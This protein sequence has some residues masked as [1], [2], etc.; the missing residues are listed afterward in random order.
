MAD[1]SATTQT[2]RLCRMP[3][4]NG[5]PWCFTQNPENAAVRHDIAREAGRSSD[6][7]RRNV[8][9]AVEALGLGSRGSVQALLSALVAAEFRG[10]IAPARTRN[11]L[12]TVELLQR[13]HAASAV[14]AGKRREVPSSRP[15]RPRESEPEQREQ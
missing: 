12:R 4:Q 11:I 1:C 9:I 10:Q 6:R 2:G 13:H 15:A 8:P 7:S 14:R 3:P 5:L